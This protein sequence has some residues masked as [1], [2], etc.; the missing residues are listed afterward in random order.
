MMVKEVI[1]VYFKLS[2]YV[3]RGTRRLVRLRIEITT[4]LYSDVLR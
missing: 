2:R 1:K 3:T 4:S